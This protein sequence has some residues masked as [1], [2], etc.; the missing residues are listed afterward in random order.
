MY[1]IKI[2]LNIEHK[3]D[4]TNS[5][6]FLKIYEFYAVSLNIK[7]QKSIQND[8]EQLLSIFNIVCFVSFEKWGVD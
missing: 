2:T 4:R 1:Q 5:C 8:N 7:T 6:N 3:I